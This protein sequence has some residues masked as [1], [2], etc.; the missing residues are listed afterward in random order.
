MLFTDWTGLLW[1][2]V[3]RTTRLVLKAIALSTRRVPLETPRASDPCNPHQ[4]RNEV[5]KVAAGP[6]ARAGTDHNRQK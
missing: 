1:S 5:A 4:E 6:I 3:N 2:P